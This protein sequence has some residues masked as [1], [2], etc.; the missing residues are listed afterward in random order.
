MC[1]NDLGLKLL[2]PNPDLN[3]W[4]LAR[5]IGRCPKLIC[6]LPGRTKVGTYGIGLVQVDTRSH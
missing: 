5:P 2:V 6:G 3:A 4:R 1:V